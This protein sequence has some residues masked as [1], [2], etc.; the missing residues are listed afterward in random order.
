MGRWKSDANLLL[1]ISAIVLAVEKVRDLAAFGRNRLGTNLRGRAF[2]DTVKSAR[3]FVA[4]VLADFLRDVWVVVVKRLCGTESLDEGE[5]ARAARR[6]DLTA[7]KN[8]E[9]NSQTA[10]RSAAA[11]NKQWLVRLL[12]ARQW[13]PQ[14]LVQRLSDG[15]DADAERAGFLV[16]DV[17]RDFALH[18]AF[19]D[20]VLGKAAVLFLYRIY[21]VGEAGDAVA[22]FEVLSDLVADLDD[23]A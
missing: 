14:A 13:E 23:G 22:D 9:L 7:R 15:R 20:G 4:S 2:R 1:N 11:V 19:C 8:R 6:N 3:E 17:V 18:V 21:A 16:R 10:S 5:V 12:A